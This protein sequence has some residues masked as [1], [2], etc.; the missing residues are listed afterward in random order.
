MI[1]AISAFVLAFLVS[2]RLFNTPSIGITWVNVFYVTYLLCF[3]L[4]PI[5]LGLGFEAGIFAD[6]DVGLLSE[7]LYV[8]AVGILAFGFGGFVYRFKK[9]TPMALGS[10]PNGARVRIFSWTCVTLSVLALAAFMLANGVVI[11]KQGGYENRYLANQ[12]FGFVTL[13]MPLFVYGICGLRLTDWREKHALA[14]LAALI[15]GG[16]TYAVMGGYRQVLI[17][18]ITAVIAIGLRERKIRLSHYA[19][20]VIAVVS[21][22]FVL[23]VARYWDGGLGGSRME[24]FYHYSVDSFAPIKSVL[25]IID[26]MRFHERYDPSVLVNQFYVLVPRALWAAKPE[27]IETPSNL[28]TQEILGYGAGVTISP[29]IMGESYMVGGVVAFL[30]SMFIFGLLVKGVE[31]WFERSPPFIVKVFYFSNVLL[32]FQF[33][34]EGLSVFMYRYIVY[35]ILIAILWKISGVV[36]RVGVRSYRF[37]GRDGMLSGEPWDSSC[38]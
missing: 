24:M 3:L 8:A 34:R 14:L 27:L 30:L 32:V 28:F 2:R 6:L 19:T 11:M 17:A 15:L 10:V 31:R 12:G 16:M 4:G 13:L 7:V 35:G 37:R 1:I 21:L 36:S 20:G 26:W 9:R 23:A 18:G 29:T 5:F 33:I 25:R 22:S 38:R